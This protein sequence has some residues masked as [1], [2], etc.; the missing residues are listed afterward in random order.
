MSD[1]VDSAVPIELLE[2]EAE[3]L[4][5]VFVI[6]AAVAAMVVST[7]VTLAMLNSIAL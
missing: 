5:A 7:L 6:A 4:P 1:A 3:G 2:A